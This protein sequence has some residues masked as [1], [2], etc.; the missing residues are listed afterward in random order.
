MCG[1]V[2]SS[3]TAAPATAPSRISEVLRIII[4]EP[5][6]LRQLPTMGLDRRESRLFETQRRAPVGWNQSRGSRRYGS[7][8]PSP[9]RVLRSART[10][11]DQLI[12][13]PSQRA[14]YDSRRRHSGS[15]V[16]HKSGTARRKQPNHRQG[17][18]TCAPARVAME[19]PFSEPP[20]PSGA[21]KSLIFTPLTGIGTCPRNDAKATA[22]AS[23]PGSRNADNAGR[24]SLRAASRAARMAG[25]R[26]CSSLAIKSLRL[27][28]C[29]ARSAAR[30]PFGVERLFALGLLFLPLRDQRGHARAL[31]VE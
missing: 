6:H 17:A 7:R 10:V 15:R 13:V 20:R 11:R 14:R 1:W 21:P 19:R 28:T 12:S 22:G 27:S 26:P 16:G 4:R 9:Q 25:S 8:F 30:V 31:P 23:R 2:A 18:V 24:L 29:L 5:F 3:V